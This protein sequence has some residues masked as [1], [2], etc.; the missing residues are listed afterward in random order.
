MIKLQIP[1]DKKNTIDCMHK[2]N[3]NKKGGNDRRKE[4]HGTKGQDM[5][6]GDDNKHEIDTNENL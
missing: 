2:D 4:V 1:L 3:L 6:V 5:L